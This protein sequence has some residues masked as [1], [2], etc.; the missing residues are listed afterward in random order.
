MCEELRSGEGRTGSKLIS[1]GAKKQ[2]CLTESPRLA[3]PNLKIKTDQKK[4]QQ[5]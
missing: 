2:Q 1:Y 3:K 5:L 4:H